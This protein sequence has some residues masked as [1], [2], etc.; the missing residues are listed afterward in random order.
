[1]QG[2]LEAIGSALVLLSL[3]DVFL[4]VLYVR[5]GTSLISDRLARWIWRLFRFV[6]RWV[7]DNNHRIMSF[8]GA[9]ILLLIIAAWVLL[10]VFGFALIALPNLGTGIR[11]ASGITPNGLPAAIYFSGSN[12][13]TAGSSDLVPATKAMRLVAVFCPLIGMSIITLTLTYLL[14]VYQALMR[15][16]TFALRLHFATGATGDAAELIAGLGAGGDFAGARSDLGSLAGE[17]VDL[18]ESH[19]FFP[20]L[21]FF[22]FRDAHYALSR[23]TTITMDAATLIRSALDPAHYAPLQNCAA[24]TMLWEGGTHLLDEMARVLLPESRQRPG[25]RPDEDTNRRWREHYRAAA[26]RLRQAGIRTVPDEQAGAERY[27]ELRAK[28]DFSLRGFAAY[29]DYA[30][31]ERDPAAHG[32]AASNPNEVE[33]VA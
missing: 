21:L 28:W 8:G 2:T 23:M 16:N 14:Q 20:M 30:P 17:M 27:I 13:A 6:D 25:P 12:L 32:D 33:A 10:L 18:Y 9:S 3:A 1:M 11:S 5:S 29:M 4:T 15:R 7:P 22:R 26:G 24:S 31:A 19:H